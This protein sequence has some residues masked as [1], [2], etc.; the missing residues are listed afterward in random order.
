[1]PLVA[2]DDDYWKGI[3]LN[4]DGAEMTFYYDPKQGLMREEEVQGR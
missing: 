4:K 2:V 3:V 1:M